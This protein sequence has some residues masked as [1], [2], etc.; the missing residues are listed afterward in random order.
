MSD[1]NIEVLESGKKGYGRYPTTDNMIQAIADDM[2]SAAGKRYSIKTI[3]DVGA[4]DGAFLKSPILRAD[5]NHFTAQGIEKSAEKVCQWNRDITFVGGDFFENTLTN[6]SAEIIFC[7]PPHSNYELWAEK[8]INESYAAA[9]YLVL[10]S[11]WQD[12]ERIE[13]ALMAR[14]FVATV[15]FEDNFL[16][17]DQRV[18]AQVDLIRVVAAERLDK[19]AMIESLRYDSRYE[20]DGIRSGELPFSL[21]RLDSQDA[22]SDQ[23]SKIFPNLASISEEKEYDYEKM[24]SRKREIFQASGTLVDMVDFYVKDQ[25]QIFE[26]YKKLDSL[27]TNLFRELNIDIEVIKKTLKERLKELRSSYWEA[28]IEHYKPIDSRL[29]RKYRKLLYNEVINDYKDIDF[30]LSNALTVTSI[31]FATASEYNNEQVK[32]FFFDISAPENIKKYKSNQKVF[33]QDAPRYSSKR[34]AEHHY[35]LDYRIIKQSVYN[36]NTDYWSGQ[37]ETHS[38]MQVIEDICVIAKIVGMSGNIILGLH[39]HERS[40]AYGKKITTNIRKDDKVTEL[41]TIKFYKN[42][43][44]HLSLSKEFLLRLNI[45]IGKLLGWVKNPAEAFEEMQESDFTQ[46]EFNTVWNE[47]QV[48]HL[49]ESDIKAIGFFNTNE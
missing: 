45:Y 31:V 39:G 34:K 26:N 41:F 43:N 25:E 17:A 15:I 23:I 35:T 47:T 32:D 8:V 28:F 6:K 36:L 42:G 4:G 14:N 46:D 37:L 12:S 33:E 24:A 19:E 49:D 16:T 27:D 44:Q 2:A 30:T 48:K 38:V 21:H 13:N 10:P 9:T 18:R 20:A 3:L 1:Q 7:N 40:V 22:M 5:N 29:T 11:E